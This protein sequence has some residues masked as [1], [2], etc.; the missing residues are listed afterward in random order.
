MST[1]LLHFDIIIVDAAASNAGKTQELQKTKR[2][3]EKIESELFDDG[4]DMVDHAKW[5][6][7][8]CT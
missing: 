6:F 2:G 1:M 8:F 7:I 4:I 3:N 5:F